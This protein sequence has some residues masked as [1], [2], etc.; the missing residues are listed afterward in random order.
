MGQ[1][2]PLGRERCRKVAL[3]SFRVSEARDARGVAASSWAGAA[4]WSGPVVAASV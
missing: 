4:Q 2:R 3:K 1:A